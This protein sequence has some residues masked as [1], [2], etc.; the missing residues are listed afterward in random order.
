M[1]SGALNQ[2]LRQSEPGTQQP[3][4]A[5]HLA[6]IRFMIVSGKMK[7]PVKNENLDLRRK[8]MTLFRSLAACG[9]YADSQVTGNLL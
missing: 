1:N 8:R 7:Q 3:F 4:P 5:G 2:T 6:T 9:G